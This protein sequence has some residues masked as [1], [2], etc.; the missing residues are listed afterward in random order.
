MSAV[1]E[2][3]FDFYY[4]TTNTWFI[5]EG[6][7]KSLFGLKKKKPAKLVISKYMTNTVTLVNSQH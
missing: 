1:A 5:L 4:M 6:T 7:Q 3:T 2:Y